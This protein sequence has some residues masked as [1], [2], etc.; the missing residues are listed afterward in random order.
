LARSEACENQAFE[1][2]GRVLGLQFHIETNAASLKDI[3]KHCRN[4][5]VDGPWVQSEEEI[6]AGLPLH[7]TA[8]QQLLARLL[9]QLV[10]TAG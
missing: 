10:S 9:D 8:N 4:E 5:L 7:A 1:I 6:L 3:L 2:D